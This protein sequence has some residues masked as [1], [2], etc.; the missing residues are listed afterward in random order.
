MSS[1]RARSARRPPDCRPSRSTDCRSVRAEVQAGTSPNATSASTATPAPTSSIRG[2]ADAVPRRGTSTGEYAASSCKPHRASATPATVASAAITSDSVSSCRTRRRRSAPIADR[3]ASSRSRSVARATSSPATFAQATS[4]RNATAPTSTCSGRRI[5]TRDFVAERAD[6]PAWPS[7]SRPDARAAARS[8]RSRAP[9]QPPRP[10]RPAAIARSPSS[11]D[12][13]GTTTIRP[14]RI[15]AVPT[16]PRASSNARK[17]PARTSRASRPATRYGDAVQRD[18]RSRDVRA[19]A[20]SAP[21]QSVRQ[22]HDAQPR[23]RVLRLIEVAPER[24]MDAE[25]AEVVPRDTHPVELRGAAVVDDRRL[26]AA[27]D[28][29]LLE[30]RHARAPVE[31]RFESDVADATAVVARSGDDETICRR[32]RARSQSTRDRPRCRSPSPRRCRWR[33]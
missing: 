4:R 16:A 22:H 9:P 18:G 30:R 33:A 2:S 8:A 29:Q 24:R 23:R 12:T 19:R 3:T 14:P 25:H 10:S 7:R 5:G 32:I 26:P 20:K 15:P 17:S 13:I 6:A 11:A 1:S 21:P 27:D 28:R 31:R